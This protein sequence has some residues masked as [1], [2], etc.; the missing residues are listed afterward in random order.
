MYSKIK[1]LKCNN[2]LLWY[3]Q[4]IGEEFDVLK[5]EANAYWCRERQHPFCLNWVLKEDAELKGKD[6]T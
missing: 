6:E 4:H 1:V 5:E 2:S 3:A